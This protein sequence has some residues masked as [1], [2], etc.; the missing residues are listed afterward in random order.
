MGF[1]AAIRKVQSG[2]EHSI[3]FGIDRYHPQRL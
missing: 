3:G 1:L 2:S